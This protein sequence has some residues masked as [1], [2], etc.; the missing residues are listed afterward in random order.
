MLVVVALHRAVRG[1]VFVDTVGRDEHGGHHRKAA[2]RRSDHIAHHVAVVVLAGPDVAALAAD[3]ACHGVVDQ[4]VKILDA[5]LGKFFL[6]FRIEYFLKNIFKAV[7]VCFRNRIFRREPDVLFRA[8]RVIEAG[9]REAADALVDVVHALNDARRAEVVD[10]PA[11]LGAVRLCDDELRLCASGHGHLR[12]LI[13]IAVCVAGD[14]DRLRPARDER[15]DALDE[16]RRAEHRAVEDRADRA[17]RRFP[18]L[19]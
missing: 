8:E 10:R 18:H 16:D 2:V 12:I 15:R 14:R 4:R 11:L 17:V 9:A 1:L 5:D 13:D 6:I 3:N 7:V 19:C